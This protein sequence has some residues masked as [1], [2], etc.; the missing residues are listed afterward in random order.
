MSK[1]NP[2]TVRNAYA[3]LKHEKVFTL[4]RVI[5]ILNCSSRS[6]Q[7]KMKQWNTYTS[8]NKNGRYYT[9]SEVPKFNEYGLWRYN[10]KYFSKHGNLKRTVNY[11]ICQSET[12]LTADRI[13]KII[14]LLPRSFMHHFRETP[15]ICREKMDGVYVYFASDPD[16]Y[17]CQ[18][19]NRSDALTPAVKPIADTDAVMILAALIRHHNIS[20]E[21]IMALPETEAMKLSPDAIGKFFE[22][23]GLLKKT[24]GT[25]LLNCLRH[26]STN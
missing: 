26:I 22:H 20:A 10:D 6:A 24:S 19:D 18:A 14:G 25:G 11:L 8:Y 4:N 1:I 12:G 5:S 13:G 16:K 3:I 9:L 17:N 2:Q 21:E 7:Y 23:H 15:H